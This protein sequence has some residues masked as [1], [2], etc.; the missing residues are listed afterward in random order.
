MQHCEDNLKARR[1]RK[2]KASPE[3]VSHLLCAAAAA[4]ERLDSSSRGTEDC[5]APWLFFC[6][7][8]GFFVSVK[9]NR[10]PGYIHLE[11]MS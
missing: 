9:E 4:A 1:Q 8:W 5:E 2:C 3:K 7:Y 11:D 10:I 6:C